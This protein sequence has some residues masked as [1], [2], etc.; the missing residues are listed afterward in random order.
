MCLIIFPYYSKVNKSFK[1]N[2]KF[3]IFPTTENFPSLQDFKL[4]R[5]KISE[6]LSAY[7]SRIL[8]TTA[9]VHAG[10][11]NGA[12][13][14]PNAAPTP[15]SPY[16]TAPTSPYS[17][18]IDAELAALLERD[19]GLIELKNKARSFQ[20]DSQIYGANNNNN[21]ATASCDSYVPCPAPWYSLPESD[22]HHQR[23]NYENNNNNLVENPNIVEELRSSGLVA[24][25]RYYYYLGEGQGIKVKIKESTKMDGKEAR[26]AF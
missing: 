10:S 6:W 2:L 1:K 9:G 4:E 22:H 17:G 16:P 19:P 7:D 24:P 14:S 13:L 12:L 20:F 5:L 8:P 18:G 15:T 21:G 3:E 11:H 25:K 26:I 23:R